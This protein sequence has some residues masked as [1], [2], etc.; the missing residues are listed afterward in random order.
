MIK[1]D[2]RGMIDKQNTA[3]IILISEFH[4]YIDQEKF[5]RKIKN[6]CHAYDLTLSLPWTDPDLASFCHNLDDAHLFDKKRA[7]E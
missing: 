4:C 6:A 3:L 5:I 7:Q 1:D 2:K